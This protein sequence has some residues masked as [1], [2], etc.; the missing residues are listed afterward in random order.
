M[1]KMLNEVNGAG[2]DPGTIFMTSTVNV[3]S[4][5]VIGKIYDPGDCEFRQLIKEM[6]INYKYCTIDSMMIKIKNHLIIF[7]VSHTCNEIIILSSQNIENYF[8]NLQD[9]ICLIL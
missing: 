7:K 1:V 6:K 8:A 4:G 3:I 2:I 9:I 5:V